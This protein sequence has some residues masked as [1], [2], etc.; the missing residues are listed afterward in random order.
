GKVGGYWRWR[1]RADALNDH[2]IY[3]LREITE[4]Y[5]RAP[6]QQQLTKTEPITAETV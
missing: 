4:L 6:N 3:R 5:G 2:L 1:Y